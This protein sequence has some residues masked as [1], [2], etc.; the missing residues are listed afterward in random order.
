M[1]VIQVLQRERNVRY[2]LL[3]PALAW[4]LGFTIYPL[5]YAVRLSVFKESLS[6]IRFVGLDNYVRAFGDERFWNDIRVTAEFVSGS[7]ALELFIGFI[8]AWMASK[9]IRG[10]RLFRLIFT[11]PLFA[12]PVAV[13]YIGL[14]IFHEEDGIANYLLHTVLALGKV[15]WFSNG[16][17]ALLTC[18]LLNSW[19]WISFTFLVSTAGIM[20]LPRDPL[21]AAIV[22]GA[23]S[24]QVFRFVTFPLLRP[25][26]LTTLLFKVVYSLKVFDI[27]FNLTE[28]GPG[29]ST[30]VYSIFVFRAGLKYLDVGY[31][32]AL[33]VIFLVVVLA[34]CAILISRMRSTYAVD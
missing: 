4:I 26:I 29:I 16:G 20:A 33:S 22:D 21:E 25:I 6:G 2:V 18:I 10:Q 30:E 23:T 9:P 1:A 7:A 5:F 15:P 28:G 32:S 34:A 3:I 11:V 14:I 8:L 27:P 24:R 19:Q 12:C 13:A 17:V 31:A